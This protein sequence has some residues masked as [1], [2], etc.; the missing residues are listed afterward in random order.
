MKVKYRIEV[1]IPEI[2]LTLSHE[3]EFDVSESFNSQ[4]KDVRIGLSERIR[5]KIAP[6][7]SWSIAQAVAEKRIEGNKND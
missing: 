5:S 7:I 6:Q 4:S 2:S 1:E 3:H